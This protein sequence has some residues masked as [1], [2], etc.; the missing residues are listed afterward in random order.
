MTN[1][2]MHPRQMRRH[3]KLDYAGTILADLKT[4]IIIGSAPDATRAKEFDLSD[5][6]SIVAVNNAWQIR[7]DWTHLIY[8]GDF[9]PNRLPTNGDGREVVT[10]EDYVLANNAYGG[11]VY[12]GGS[13]AFTAGYWA[14]HSLR[15]DIL[16]FVGCDM[17]YDQS[18]EKTHFYGKGEPDP[19]RDDPS[20]QSL[21]AKAN[22][23]L[24]TGLEQGCLCMN[25]STKQQSRLTFPRLDAQALTSG[26]WEQ[27]IT[28]LV[29]V[30]DAADPH[31][32]A[33]AQKAEA[34]AGIFVETG[35]YWE[36]PEKVDGQ[37]LA[38]IDQLWLAAMAV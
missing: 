24:L 7:K 6:S 15:P 16:A 21:E 10:F 38:A 5:V 18:S 9:D 1:S 14:L 35:D 17:I 2:L 20:L 4:V 22:R 23:L 3:P 8:P 29:A 32:V 25:L 19:L 31:A 34:D 27:R 12:A 37:R 11:I 28:A 26:L 33:L 36:H 30:R 13:M